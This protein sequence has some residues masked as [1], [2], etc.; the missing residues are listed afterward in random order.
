[1]V[2]AFTAVYVAIIAKIL[3]FISAHEKYSNILC[4]CFIVKN[5]CVNKYITFH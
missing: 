2:V 4:N 5:N 3:S 1:M